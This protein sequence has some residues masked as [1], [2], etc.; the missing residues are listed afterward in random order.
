VIY[1]GGETFVGKALSLRPFVWIGLISYSL[2]LWHW[3]ILVYA[4]Q[5]LI[6]EKLSLAQTVGCILATFLLATLSWRFVETP[7]RKL[8]LPRV[9]LFFG[10]GA[11]VGS[12][13][14]VGVGIFAL[15]GF[16]NRFSPESLSLA[17]ANVAARPDGCAPVDRFLCQVGS[18]QAKY[19][20]WGDSHAGALS[21]AIS[22]VVNGPGLYAIFN[23]CPPLPSVT[24]QGLR[25]DDLPNCKA[26]NRALLERIRSDQ[27]I[28]IVIIAAFWSNYK[29][30]EDDVRSLLTELKDKYVIIVGDNPTPEF[31][32]PKVLALNGSFNLIKPNELPN[33]FKIGRDSSNV[34][35]LELSDAL[36]S[37]GKCPLRDGQ[38]ALYA[39]GNQISAYAA[40]TVIT[41]FMKEQFSR[42][43]PVAILA[44]H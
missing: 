9:R 2:Y 1:G 40:N 24:P 37:R 7:F 33:P 30:S 17:Q 28:D 44:K 32:V 39:D 19:V 13:V 43:A 20:L 5:A 14:A 15:N 29:F 18:G 3:P 31:N 26:R 16:P 34:K 10:A 12:V 27:N 6:S 42:L 25:G 41:A 4:K 35:L 11:F 38:R 23:S 36:C 21:P 8:P 22:N